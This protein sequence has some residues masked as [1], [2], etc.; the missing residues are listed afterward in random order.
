MYMPIYKV[1]ENLRSYKVKAQISI[2]TLPTVLKV[3]QYIL[4][5]DTIL[6]IDKIALKIF[7]LLLSYVK[8]FVIYSE[9]ELHYKYTHT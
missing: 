1:Y 2:N 8:C 4:L 7:D 9:Y 3:R 6:I 5:I